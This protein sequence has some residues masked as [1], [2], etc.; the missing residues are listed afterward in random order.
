[1]SFTTDNYE[2]NISITSDDQYLSLRIIDNKS[3]SIY[4]QDFYYASLSY[5][6]KHVYN[7]MVDYFGDAPMKCD[8]KI[9]FFRSQ[10]NLR[11]IM[12]YDNK[13]FT[14]NQTLD[15]PQVTTDSSFGKVEL[16]RKIDDIKSMIMTKD[17]IVEMMAEMGLG[18]PIGRGYVPMLTVQ[19]FVGPNGF[20]LSD[21]VRDDRVKSKSFT[22]ENFDNLGAEHYQSYNTIY[23]HS[24]G[25]NHMVVH[26]F[27]LVNI[28]LRTKNTSYN[29]SGGISGFVNSGNTLPARN[30]V[31]HLQKLRFLPNLKTLIICVG[32]VELFNMKEIPS[33]VEH[34][35]LVDIDYE[36]LSPND[37]KHLVNIKEF[38]LT[39]E[40]QTKLL[41]SGTEA[42]KQLRRINPDVKITIKGYPEL[43]T[44]DPASATYCTFA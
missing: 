22:L 9:E 11:I 36:I 8:A 38:I 33:T 32:T 7:F 40:L 15:V 12:T 28:K 34:L 18:V 14:I 1:M 31:K 16:N 42:F 26:Y 39:F 5:P 35:E 29:A 17:D 19:L 21:D 44:P 30:H 20:G 6:I 27:Q 10:G 37:V 43:K 2:I 24:N 4:E 41:T 3:Y 13:Y 25:H 23:K